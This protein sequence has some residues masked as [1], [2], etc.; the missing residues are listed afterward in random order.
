MSTAVLNPSAAKL[1]PREEYHR[2]AGP[3]PGL[4]LFCREGCLISAPV[5]VSPRDGFVDLGPGPLFATHDGGASWTRVPFPERDLSPDF[6][7]AEH[8]FARASGGLYATKDG[9]HTWTIVRTNV[10]LS[11]TTLDFVNPRTGLALASGARYV[12]RT[13]DGG[14]TWR[15]VPA[16]LVR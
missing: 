15:K 9:G 3:L 10:D 4:S 11:N 12:L 14:R 8:G 13:D 5:F 16:T 2:I 1:D 6:V 7:D